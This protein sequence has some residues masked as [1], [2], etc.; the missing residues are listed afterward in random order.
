MAATHR[1]RLRR[2]ARAR[3]RR[4]LVRARARAVRDPVPA[5]RRADGHAR[6]GVPDPARPLDAGDARRFEGKHFQLEDA[7]MR[8]QAAAG[9]PAARDR[10]LG[11]A[12]DAADRRRARR[13]LEHVLRRPRRV[14]AQARRARAALRRRRPRPGRHP[15]VAD[16]PR[17]AGRQTSRRPKSDCRRSGAARRP[18][19]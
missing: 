8:A 11:R 15:Q 2:P 4:R 16:L 17:G 14:P 10:R 19:G 6:R 1:P 12:P 18:S 7:R 5:H 9:A 3:D 13:R